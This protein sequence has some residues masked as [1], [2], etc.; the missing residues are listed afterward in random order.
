MTLTVNR[1]QL[2]LWLPRLVFKRAGAIRSTF[3]RHEE[4]PGGGALPCRRGG[5]RDGRATA[6]PH[7]PPRRG[8]RDYDVDNATGATTWVAGEVIATQTPSS[9]ALALAWLLQRA[10]G[11]EVDAVFSGEGD[12]PVLRGALAEM[13]RCPLV[14]EEAVDAGLQEIPKLLKKAEAVAGSSNEEDGARHHLV[15]FVA[16]PVFY[17]ATREAVGDDASL[18]AALRKACGSAAD[19][20]SGNSGESARSANVDELPR[21]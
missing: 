18:E 15:Q 19:A 4:R 3:A 5:L 12:A 1:T 9:N 2:K 16:R 20:F 14:P 8:G 21:N 13:K 7:A 10:L 6:G 17:L 11:D